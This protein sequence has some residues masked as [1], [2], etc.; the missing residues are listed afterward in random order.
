MS[1]NALDIE[2]EMDLELFGLTD[3]NAAVWASNAKP[4]FF[5][6]TKLKYSY[7]LGYG[8][9]R[10]FMNDDESKMI[11]EVT[12]ALAGENR[13]RSSEGIVFDKNMQKIVLLISK[14]ILNFYASLYFQ[15]RLP[16]KS[17]LVIWRFILQILEYR[18]FTNVNTVRQLLPPLKPLTFRQTV[19][20]FE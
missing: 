20:N 3:A 2:I 1:C 7:E 14:S 9:Q 5:D 18:L 6:G 17:I 10:I 4:N 16:R 19:V 11:A 13:Q 15:K 12:F 8:D